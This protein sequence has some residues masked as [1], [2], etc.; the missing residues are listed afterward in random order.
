M[1]SLTV[2]LATFNGAET[3]AATLGAL[4]RLEA[5]DGGWKLVVVNNGSTDGTKAIVETFADRLPLQFLDHPVANKNAALNAALA[6]VEGDLVVFADDDII[7]RPDWLVGFRRLAAENPSFAIFGAPMQPLWPSD[8]PPWIE[9]GIPWGAAF[10]AHPDDLADG[11]APSHVIWGG[12]MAVRRSVFDA[13]HRFDEAYGPRLGRNI[14]MASETE[15]T[16][17]VEKLGHACWFSNRFPVGHQIQP[18]QFTPSWLAGRAR[19]F[20][21]TRAVRH[22]AMYRSSPLRDSARAVRRLCGHG[23][24]WLLSW[25]AADRTARYRAMWGVNYEFGYLSRRIPITKSDI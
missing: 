13:G 1:P 2:I 12:N 24:R 21:A 20:G 15:F 18:S 17:R 5:P 11:P 9:H 3:I 25:P 6:H 14:L 16:W 4:S 8:P 19:R 10:A 7:A 23:A 22:K